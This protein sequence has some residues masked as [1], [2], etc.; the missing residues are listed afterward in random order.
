ML[1]NHLRVVMAHH[2]INNL[3]ELMEITG[4]SRNA[5]NKLWHDTDVETVKLGTL[6]KICDS[7]EVSLSELVEYVPDKKE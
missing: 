2:R 4:L 6:M 7:L 3:T 1:K 5:L